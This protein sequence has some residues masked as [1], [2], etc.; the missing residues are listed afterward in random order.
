MLHNDGIPTQDLEGPKFPGANASDFDII[1]FLMRKF[2]LP[3][4]GTTAIKII[5]LLSKVRCR[6]AIVK[7]CEDG[8][9]NRAHQGKGSYFLL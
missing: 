6:G 9:Y 7:A 5:N 3:D 4:D 2:D 8:D 1:G